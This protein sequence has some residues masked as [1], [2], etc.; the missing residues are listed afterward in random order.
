[1]KIYTTPILEKD[2]HVIDSV[3]SWFRLAPPKDGENQWV[4]GRSAKE[5]AK[6][7]FRKP[8]HAC[9]PQEL[10]DLLSSHD[11]LAG[12]SIFT[13]TPEVRVTLDNYP[14]ETRNADMILQ[15]RRDEEIMVISVEAKADEQFDVTIGEKVRN[16]KAASN[17]PKR[18][19][20]LCR[21][22][23]TNSP[24]QKSSIADLRYQ[25]LHA[26][27]ATVIAAG[28]RRASKALFVVHE[29]KTDKTDDRK[30]ADNHTDL[31]TFVAELTRGTT[32]SVNY[33]KA[34]GPISISGGEHVPTG[35]PL[36]IGN[37]RRITKR[38]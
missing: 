24:E 13:G 1:M 23:F 33:G 18:V 8:G 32:Q 10:D 16:A 22:I 25:L 19:D 3:D 36:Y 7:W 26:V 35:I 21:A 9:V 15:G 31:E 5:L 38:I 17:I 20:H 27:A 37:I 29:F 2:G 30:I 28:E 11:D 34:V 6:A 14:G 12:Y 4:D